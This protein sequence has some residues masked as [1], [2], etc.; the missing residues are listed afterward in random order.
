MASCSL[1]PIDGNA[2]NGNLSRLQALSKRD[3]GSRNARAWRRVSTLRAGLNAVYVASIFG[4]VARRRNMPPWELSSMAWEVSSTAWDFS[5][6]AWDFS[7]TASRR[8]QRLQC[9]YR[10]PVFSGG[11][12]QVYQIPIKCSQGASDG[13]PKPPEVLL[14]AA[15]SFRCALSRPVLWR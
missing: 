7:S 3:S 2:S 1:P 12:I 5:S 6:T 13:V 8:R 4:G 9:V 14:A 15:R 10:A 11:L